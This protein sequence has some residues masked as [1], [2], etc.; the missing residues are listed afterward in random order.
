M[1]RSHYPRF[2]HPIV[3]ETL[4]EVFGVP[5][6]S[7]LMSS[8]LKNVRFC[9][10]DASGWT[11]FG[12][13]VCRAL[14][15]AAFLQLQA[16]LHDLPTAIQARRVPT[17]PE[18]VTLDDLEL[19]TRTYNC[20]RKLGLRRGLDLLT[21]TNLSIKDLLSIQGFG[22]K[23]LLDFLTSLEALLPHRQ[24]SQTVELTQDALFRLAKRM[25]RAWYAEAIRRDDP[26][27]GHLLLA[28]DVKA[29]TLAEALDHLLIQPS[30]EAFEPQKLQQ[31]QRLR[32]RIRLMSNLLLEGE[33]MSFA[34]M[35]GQARNRKI[36]V[37][38]LGWDGQGGRT[39]REVAHEYQLT[40]ERV[41]Q[42]TEK[43]ILAS[44]GKKPFA[45]ALDRSLQLVGE[46][47]PGTADEIESI[48]AS[49][50]VTK[51]LFRLEG[52][53]SAA[54]VLGR[55]ISFRIKNLGGKRLALPVETSDLASRVTRTAR[56]IIE[57]WGVVTI[58]DIAA[59]LEMKDS[60]QKSEILLRQVFSTQPDFQWLDQ[61]NGWFWLASVPRN[62]VLNQIEK[63]L[64]VTE[65]INVSE[66]RSGISRH[67][68]MKGFAP[69]RRV[70][71]ELCRQIPGYRVE[72]EIVMADPPP[73]WEEVLSETERT[74]VNVLKKHG[75]VMQRAKLEETCLNMGMKRSTFYVYLDY[76]PVITRYTSGV[77]GLRGANVT[78]DIIE[79]LTPV[80]RRGKVLTDYGWT[81]DRKIWLGY[82]LSG[83]MITS[84]VFTVP[85]AMKRFI[86]GEF[87]FMAADGVNLG[88]VVS[89][90]E[91]AWGLGSL[92]RRRG[93]EPGDYLV[94]EFDVDAR[95]A[96]AHLGD[97][98]LL[99]E[100][101]LSKEGRG[102]VTASEV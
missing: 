71:L 22:A 10:L 70:L 52:L 74:M 4:R 47:L 55:E 5:V 64:S 61:E 56:R 19:E 48:L 79:T 27:L 51:A 46:H 33:L 82:R 67:Y 6:P 87:R 95:V 16:S 85:S 39:L 80:R 41:R 12:E 25:R 88:T 53:I 13:S 100:F 15:H 84:G 35:I 50:G 75:P 43:V 20:L 68:R 72:K 14:A 76:S 38:Y 24:S 21:I 18:G 63:I 42:V 59:A 102:Q 57:R 9:D 90:E 92:F 58:A 32:E 17:P 8:G 23:S 29:K 94:L 99:D 31:L 69:P 101:V 1:L 60:E 30:Q 34:S 2:G 66:L 81:H 65:H 40:H 44:K 36:A 45:P 91:G 83:A 26:R 11:R 49:E 62:R 98:A 86:L 89:K 7:R 93:G 37:R 3:P 78:P 97:M 77:Y 54:D 28:F 73:D 96:V